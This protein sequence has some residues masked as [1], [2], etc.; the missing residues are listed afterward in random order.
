MPLLLVVSIV[1]TKLYISGNSIAILADKVFTNRIRLQSIY[2]K[3]FGMSLWGKD[4]SA[5]TSRFVLDSAYIRCL[6]AYGIVFSVVF[7]D[8][9]V[10]ILHKANKV[11]NNRLIIL[12][13]FFL[14]MGFAETSMLRVTF[15][16]TILALLND[17]ILNTNELSG[18][19]KYG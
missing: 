11:G 13:I 14:V 15:N 2:W 8:D 12:I 1:L 3:K 6:V 16:I 19:K 18:T 7:C 17:K 10:N 5:L 9:Y 4:I